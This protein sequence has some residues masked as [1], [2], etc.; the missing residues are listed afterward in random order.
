MA[1]KSKIV[2]VGGGVGGYPAAI[3]AA[4]MG[5]EVT[6]IERADLGGTCLNRG[7]IPTKALLQVGKVIETMKE[8]EIYGVKCKGYEL[9]FPAAMARKNA[10]VS[11]LSNG[12]KSLL[13][14]KKVKVIKGTASFVDA[15]TLQ[16]AE[17]GE[18]VQGDKI[19]IASGSVPATVPIEGLDSPD[20]M[21]SDKVLEM[22]SLPASAVII[23]GGVIGVEFAQYLNTMGCKVTIVEMMPNLI[24]GV[25]KEI[26][27][28]LQKLIV[29]SGV[30]VVTSAAVKSIVHKSNENT[31][32]YTVAGKNETVTV[33]KVIL[34]VGRRPDFSLLNIDKIGIKTEKGAIVVNEYM[35]TNMPNI[36]AVGDVIGG[37]MLAHLATAEG[38]CAVQNALGH[39]HAMNYKAVPACIYTTPEIAS[40]GLTE[41]KARESHDVQV[42]RFPMRGVGK[43]LVVNEVDGLVKIVADKKYGEVL[44]VHIIGP[45][46]TDMIAEAVLG[47]N[48]EMTVEELAHTIH[49]HP[50]ISEAVMEAALTLC[51]GA[52]HM[53]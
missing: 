50:T 7:C 8:S 12:V 38:E 25:D 51:G 28:L 14:A 34:T 24:F 44:G 31:V 21:D 10:V 4:R 18:K 53:P 19:I 32:T 23:G 39:R 17:T 42:G 5:A 35:E 6:L 46:A 43:A 13:A 36:Y 40:V 9:D 29:K 37:I 22:K 33:E 48:M 26:A 45:H 3:R 27:E 20:V 52:I 2:I 15:K 49:P 47:M 11:Q 41:E 30:K 1:D 16:I